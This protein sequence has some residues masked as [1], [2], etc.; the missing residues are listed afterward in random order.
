MARNR[1]R[2]RANS[3]LNLPG[4]FQLFK[5]SRNIV[6]DNIWIF[7]PLFAVSL[8]FSLHSW[9]WSPA[10]ATGQHWADR[11]DSFSSGWSFSPISTYTWGAFIGFSI[12]WL[13]F[14]LAAGT[15]VQIMSQ[16]AQLDAVEHKPL[17]FT[18]LW[19]VV[20]RLGWRLLGLYLLID[21]YILVGL[22]LLIIPGLIMIRR[23]FLAPYVMIDTKCGIK[24][25]MERSA[26]MTKPYSGSIWGI[27]GVSFLIGLVAIVPFIGSLAAFM[28]A[29]LYSVAPAIRYQELK[30]LS[31]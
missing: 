7:G 10:S 2:A 20:K 18:V 25:A 21:L 27:I 19:Q 26:A 6:L 30:K 8:I 31:A 23:Y 9:I 5:P 15:I 1:Q 12:I 17:D 16:A 13:L 3:P 14:V 29:A 24:E 4:A 11:F 22:I 28:L